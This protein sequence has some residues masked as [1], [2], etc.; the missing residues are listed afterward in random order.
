MSSN[1]KVNS[2][3]PAT[4]TEIGIGTT[5]GTIDFRCPA[6]FGGNVTIGGTL[7]YD[8][9]INID[10][11][12]IVTA[13]SG[14]KVTGGQLDV[15]SNIK[16][17]NAGVITA[18][19]F[20]GSGA[21]LTALNGS[22]IASGTVAA[23][24]IDNLAA[25][26]ITSGTVATARLG[27][28]TANSSSFLRGDQT[29][30][31]VTS[32]TINS[33]AANRVI[34]GSG[35]ANTL[36][37]EST[38]TFT[39]GRL[40]IPG[41][42]THSVTGTAALQIGETN[43][44]GSKKGLS[45]AD[46]EAITGGTGPWISLKHGPDGGTQRTHEIYSYLG[47]LLISA[48]S[49]EDMIFWT[50][51]NETLRI[52]SGGEVVATSQVTVG[53]NVAIENDTGKFTVG[54]SSDLQMFH[55]GG[56]S[57]IRNTNN[58]ASLYL[59]ASS[60]GTNNI[61]CNPN[62]STQLFHNGNLQ[63]YTDSSGLR[64][65][66]D[67]KLVFGSSSDFEIYHNAGAHNYLSSVTGGSDIVFKTTPSGGSAAVRLRLSASNA[68][69]TVYGNDN[70]FYGGVSGT[71]LNGSLTL[72]SVGSAVYQNLI[73]KSS[74]GTNQASIVG[75]YGGAILFFNS[76]AYVWSINS[77]G[78]RL[79]LTNTSLAPRATS[80]VLDLG[81]TT[82]RFRRTYTNGITVNTANTNT[83]FCI[84]GGSSANV[85]SIRNTTLGNGNVGILFSTQDHSGGREKAAIYHQETHGTAHYGGDFIF[86][87]NTA[88]GGATQVSASDERFR[89]KRN[90]AATLQ[91]ALT[92]NA[93][94]IRLK[95]NIQPIENSLEKVKSL[96]GFT[97]NWNKTAQ[98]L[99]FEGKEHDELQVGLSAQDVEKIQPEVVKPAPVDKDYKTIQYEKLVPLL[100]EA[101]KEQQEQIE[102]LK[103]EVA[104][105]KSS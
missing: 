105:L 2:L 28:G 34:T 47:D 98:D 21:S 63:V 88:T 77:Q 29:W 61:K 72:R 54:T 59:Q 56:S 23:A 26:K 70:I 3:V 18:T 5:G 62:G 96:S 14:L 101:I 42:G 39:S 73:F 94:D 48:D 71:N 16:A 24:R 46:G 65:N 11:I 53:G 32:T 58:N 79:E 38:L 97:Y 81:T 75:Y 7:T 50:G 6:T 82:K 80:T 83:N 36:N 90:G 27:S 22:N 33:N 95:E 1:L 8:E 52:R 35:T 85:M 91:G 4:G 87:L 19:A 66:D 31:A 100:V 51:G 103:T 89:I 43:Q 104:V 78:E 86:C 40:K 84:N 69:L 76:T 9:V 45:I 64:A 92:Q 60:S 20:S 30:A 49:N 55:D 99:G 37:A 41:N 57:I 74:D 15:G 93:S 68:G 10:S 102:T 25:S 67:K 44:Q 13:R 17:G 12:G